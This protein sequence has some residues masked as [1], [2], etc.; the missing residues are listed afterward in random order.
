M[1]AA[2]GDHIVIRS[3]H[4]GEHVRK[5]EILEA[6]GAGGEPPWLIRWEDSGHEALLYPGP[7]AVVEHL[8][9]D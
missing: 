8:P 9:R 6:R 3:Q 1:R 5:G 2:V 4:V 7:D